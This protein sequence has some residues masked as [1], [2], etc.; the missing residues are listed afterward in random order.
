MATLCVTRP[1]TNDFFIIYLLIDIYT[2]AHAQNSSPCMF[3]PVQFLYQNASST[4]TSHILNTVSITYRFHSFFCFVMQQKM[5]TNRQ[6]VGTTYRSRGSETSDVV[7]YFFFATKASAMELRSREVGA[8]CFENKFIR[9]HF[10][11]LLLFQ[12]CH[13]KNL[14]LCLCLHLIHSLQ[15]AF[16]SSSL[17]IS[18][19][20]QGQF[21]AAAAQRASASYN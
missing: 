20:C 21:Q 1:I 3:S 5:P 13:N 17:T 8:Y 6:S 4:S 9:A 12:N 14:V 19:C 11:L 2:A 10:Q 16:L 7:D 18:L 15:C